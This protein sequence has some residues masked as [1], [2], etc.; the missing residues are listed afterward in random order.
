MPLTEHEQ[1]TYIEY[2]NLYVVRNIIRCNFLSIDKYLLHSLLGQYFFSFFVNNS[3][4][5][6][7][8][9]FLQKKIFPYF[10]II[11]IFSRILKIRK[12]KKKWE[13]WQTL[14]VK[15]PTSRNLCNVFLIEYLWYNCSRSRGVSSWAARSL[16]VSL[17]VVPLMVNSRKMFPEPSSRSR[18]SLWVVSRSSVAKSI[19][20]F[21]I[22]SSWWLLSRSHTVTSNS[23]PK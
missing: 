2:Y 18:H 22:R 11:Y 14:T 23:C 17:A 12:Q 15:W 16:I 9:I 21:P 19:T 13:I 4:T 3:S 1:A 10:W 6:P 5:K 8:R 7:K 20:V